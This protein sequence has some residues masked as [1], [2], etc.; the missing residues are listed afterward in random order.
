MASECDQGGSID[1]SLGKAISSGQWTACRLGKADRRNC[2]SAQV[3]AEIVF[4]L[5]ARQQRQIQRKA[6]LDA[7]RPKPLQVRARQSSAA[8]KLTAA[9]LRRSILRS[10]I[11]NSAF[12]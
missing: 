5:E 12:I 1:P 10:A 6:A 4:S 3:R 11:V 2:I 8:R 9:S 7:Q